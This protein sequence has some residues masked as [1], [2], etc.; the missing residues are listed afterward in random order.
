MATTITSSTLTVTITEAI[1]IGGVVRGNTNKISI[2]GINEVSQRVI[3]V[4]LTATDATT[5]T[6]LLKL[7]TTASAGTWVAADVKYIRITNLDDTSTCRIAL[8]TAAKT[9]WFSL[10]AGRTLTLFNDDALYQ[11]TG[12][13]VWTVGTT[14]FDAIEEIVGQVGPPTQQTDPIDL[15]VFIA[16]A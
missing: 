11:S 6:T 10:E 5:E 13:L 9:A 3:T 7:D 8:N 2:S 14:T 16:S 15:E 1:T 4:P 12:V